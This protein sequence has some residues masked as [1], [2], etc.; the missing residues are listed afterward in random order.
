MTLVMSML[1]LAK[2]SAIYLERLEGKTE[3]MAVNN[4]GEV[5]RRVLN[6]GK[7]CVII[8]PGH[9]GF[10]PGKVGVNG[11]LEKDINLSIAQKVGEYLEASDIQVIMTRSEDVGLY[12]EGSPNKKSQDMNRRLGLIERY[13]PILVLSIHQ[14][15][16]TSEKVEGFQVFYHKGNSF[17]R[18]AAELLE[19]SVMERTKQ[20]KERPIK[21]NDSYFLLTKSTVPV[22]I[23]ECG[24]LSNVGESGKLLEEEY[25]DRMAYSLHMAVVQFV[26]QEIDG[27]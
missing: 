19:S 5:G 18:K 3:K 2:D 24:F 6:E 20:S 21:D 26:H 16:Y 12:D 7:P 23:V 9:G 10:D 13:K 15:S 8:D 4:L 11:V 17:G 27:K 25:Q 22:V 1:F 14:N